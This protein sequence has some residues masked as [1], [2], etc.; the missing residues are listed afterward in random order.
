MRSLL[1]PHDPGSP[2]DRDGVA[3]AYPWPEPLD[4]SGAW[5]RAM[6]VTSLD[7]AAAGASGL[8]GDISSK[9]DML[10]FNAVRRFADV[11]LVGAGTLRAEQYSPMRTQP[12]DAER[13]EA[14]GLA[15][16]PVLAFVSRSLD[17]PWQLPLWAE[18]TLR[19][20][21]I[22]PI[23]APAEGVALARR[24][25]DL[26][27]LEAV[28]PRTII[29]AL[30]ARGLRRILCE[31][32][33][34]LLHDLV[35]ADLLDEA[36]ISISPRFAGTATSPTTPALDEIAEFRLVNV[37]AGDDFLMARYLGPGR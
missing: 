20:I 18:S 32:G 1:S 33:P 7:G 25:A 10:V 6:M 5:V 24:H 26:V 35:A 30:V 31:G 28:T 19:P 2:I 15:P 16:A 34:R 29:D 3:D 4:R 9:A 23:S 36:D 8:S 21:V 14:E 13:R 11:V 17:L 12:A 22:A 37:L 27:L